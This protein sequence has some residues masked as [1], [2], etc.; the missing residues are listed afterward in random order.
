MNTATNGVDVHSTEVGV[1]NFKK[2]KMKTIIQ[3]YGADACLKAYHL[4]L[5]GNGAL[6][7]GYQLINADDKND[8]TTEFQYENLGDNLIDKGKDLFNSL[9]SKK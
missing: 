4:H 2:Q 6:T 9:K 8:F 3:R 7:V 1:I 5:E